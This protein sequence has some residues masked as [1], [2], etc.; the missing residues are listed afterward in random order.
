MSSPTTISTTGPT[1][2][3]LD[4]S[5]GGAGS[6]DRTVGRG[7]SAPGSWWRRWGRNRTV[8]WL[9]AV[10]LVLLLVLLTVSLLRNAA[11]SQ[12]A[13]DPRSTT[14]TGSAALAQLLSD[15]GVSVSTTDQVREAVKR[16][17][18]ST[19]LVVANGDRLSES[20]ADALLGAPSSRLVLV[21]PNTLAQP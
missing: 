18:A 7:R 14:S 15:Q 9:V 12:A 5:P 19:T 1:A 4:D 6:A 8:R 20:D 17:D 21:R 16:S 3:T 10:V 2:A 11:R 13:D